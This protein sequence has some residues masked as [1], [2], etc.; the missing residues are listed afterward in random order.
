MQDSLGNNRH[1]PTC[2]QAMKEASFILRS[3]TGTTVP[4]LLSCV[5]PK[6]GNHLLQGLH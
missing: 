6:R 5:Q 1:L 3:V 2:R 4:S